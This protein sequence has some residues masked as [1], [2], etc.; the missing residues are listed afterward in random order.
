MNKKTIKPL[1]TALSNMLIYLIFLEI[2][3]LYNNFNTMILVFKIFNIIYL[4]LYII[5]YFL[6]IKQSKYAGIFGI[7]TS[8][9]MFLGMLH[10]D[11]ITF[12]LGFFIL[13]FSIK[14]H[15]DLNN[16]KI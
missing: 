9:I 5:E 7:I 11:F 10:Y 16:Q 15:I 6:A 4:V 8:I 13:G 2:Y 1:G 3:I 14:Y 12:F